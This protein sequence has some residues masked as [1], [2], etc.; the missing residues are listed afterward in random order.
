MRLEI[1]TP[2][3]RDL[4]SLAISPDGLHVAFAGDAS[5]NPRTVG[6]RPRRRHRA[7]PPRDR[8]RA[9]SRSGRRTVSRWAF[10]A[11]NKL[12]R[13]DLKGGHPQVLASAPNPQ[14]GSWAA[15][16]TILFAPTQ[17]T[18]IMRV[19][20]TGGDVAPV[21]KIERPQLGNLFPHVLRDGAHFL[22]TVTGAD[23]VRGIYVGALDG[24]AARRL[25]PVA[26][27]A[28]GTAS[29][30]IFFARDGALLAQALD[31]NRLE[32]AGEPI[33]VA[34]AV[35][36]I[37]APGGGP[38]GAA[39]SASAGGVVVY[40]GRPPEDTNQLVWYDRAGREVG[41]VG[42][43][44]VPGQGAALSPD[45]RQMAVS[46]ETDGNRDIWLIDLARGVSSR[47]TFDPAT[48]G[49]PLW[50]PDGARVFF[51]SPRGAVLS[52]YQKLVSGGDEQLLLN[53]G[54]NINTA[55]V[56]PDGRV[57]LYSLANP[58]TLR[59]L[60][61][62]PLGPGEKPFPIVQTPNQDL[63]GQF[64]PNGA[65]LAYQS[66]ESGRYEVSLRP[67]RETGH[68]VQVSASGGTQPRWRGDGR[69]L[70]YLDLNRRLIATPVSFSKDLQ[71]VTV[72]M[73]SPLF[74][75]QIGGANTVQGEYLVSPDGQ[76]FLVDAPTHVTPVPIT[77]IMNW[78]PPR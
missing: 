6:A 53:V 74:A 18:S 2:P 58:T 13:I 1:S 9:V 34:D 67:F 40:R 26:S 47:F 10:F 45:G 39:V 61:A 16:G 73:P 56:S 27:A 54:K 4:L 28:V 12:K 59:D 64:A 51:S 8:R 68:V 20:A 69:E 63:N 42:T 72:G 23:E 24:S 15:D 77:V 44:S 14:G 55:D 49:S 7:V 19:R 30:H 33:R 57:L 62:V 46:R 65:W 5:P 3:T 35:A 78:R 71:T 60:W 36:T 31:L 32:L 70:F 66:N 41:R 11:D 52:L 25:L 37:G 75:T 38:Q 22:Y 48:D 43:P 21:T 29:G 50:S 76:R 17:I